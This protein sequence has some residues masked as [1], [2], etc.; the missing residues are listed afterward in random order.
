MN[1]EKLAR[2]F[3]V[4][5]WL[6]DSWPPATGGCPLNIKNGHKGGGA[7]SEFVCGDTFLNNL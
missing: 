1:I 6:N 7:L 4:R 2:K 5:K 3:C